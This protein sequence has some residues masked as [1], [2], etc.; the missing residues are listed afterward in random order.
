MGHGHPFRAWAHHPLG[1]VLFVG[2]ALLAPVA[3]VRAD[4]RATVDRVVDAYGLHI[5]VLVG[6]VWMWRVGRRSGGL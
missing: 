1:P 5:A 2:A 4:W 3:L 6:A